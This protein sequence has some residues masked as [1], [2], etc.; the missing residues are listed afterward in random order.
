MPKVYACSCNIVYG[1]LSK[2]DVI[3]TNLNIKVY[4]FSFKPVITSQKY[5]T[6]MIYI[7]MCNARSKS[8]IVTRTNW[9]KMSLKFGKTVRTLRISQNY[10]DLIKIKSV[11]YKHA[12][13]SNIIWL[14][15]TWLLI[16]LLEVANKK[17]SFTN[18]NPLFI[19]PASTWIEIS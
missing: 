17:P 7:H 12:Q 11:S 2:Q 9:E 5:S 16:L 3:Y 4:N 14:Y 10:L 1:F 13:T 18:K 6:W 15:K 8:I 19:K